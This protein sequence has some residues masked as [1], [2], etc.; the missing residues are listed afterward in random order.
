MITNCFRQLTLILAFTS[1]LAGCSSDEPLSLLESKRLCSTLRPD[2]QD[3]VDGSAF[4][5]YPAQAE[6]LG[7]VFYSPKADNC[8]YTVKIMTEVSGTILHIYEL[9]DAFTHE[10]LEEE[11]G[12][13]N[14]ISA[15]HC[16]KSL[17]EAEEDFGNV[18][19]RYR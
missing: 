15:S 6:R 3:I 5:S 18:V 17:E 13:L 7:L 2:I 9:K 1:L 10:E 8:M 4:N 12:C 14:E 11:R 16:T 19:E